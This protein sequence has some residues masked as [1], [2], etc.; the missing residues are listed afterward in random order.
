MAGSAL[1]SRTAAQPLGGEGGGER[2]G[3]TPTGGFGTHSTGQSAGQARRQ[4]DWC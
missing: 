3:K 4:V 1:S 2:K